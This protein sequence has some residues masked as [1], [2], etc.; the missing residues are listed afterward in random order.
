VNNKQ[1]F[2]LPPLTNFAFSAETSQG[3]KQNIARSRWNFMANL[4]HASHYGQIKG[5]LPA[6]VA[7]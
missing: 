1:L 7:L 5:A 6:G 3:Y 4:F 2:S